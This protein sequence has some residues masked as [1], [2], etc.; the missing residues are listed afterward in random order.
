[1]GGSRLLRWLPP[2]IKHMDKESK[3]IAMQTIERI[4]K[5]PP[6][7]TRQDW[8]ASKKL[9][10]EHMSNEDTKD[11]HIKSDIDNLS[12]ELA[13]FAYNSIKGCGKLFYGIGNGK[14]AICSYC[15]EHSGQM[16]NMNDCRWYCSEHK[17]FG[18]L[19]EKQKEKELVKC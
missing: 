10:A 16:Y 1:M 17:W 18:N 8:D 6:K 2:P 7:I 13:G 3:R 15:G 19:T 5:N 11:R 9:L 12:R 14:K 4:K